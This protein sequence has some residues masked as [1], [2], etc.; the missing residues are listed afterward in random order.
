[1][2]PACLLTLPLLVAIWLVPALAFAQDAREGFV[3]VARV[4]FVFAGGGEAEAECDGDCG[5]FA[6]GDNDYDDESGP[7]IGMDF[8]G[9]VSPKLRLGG[10]LMYFPT[11]ELDFDDGGDFEV[12]SDLLT[13]FIVEGV[14][15]VSPTVALA[16]R[17]QVGAMF[18]FPDDDLEESIDDTEAACDALPGDC[19]VDD[20]PYVG[21]TF[22]LGGGAIFDVGAVALRADL[23]FQWYTINVG[24]TDYNGPVTDAE[25]Y[26]NVSGSRLILAGG[27][28]F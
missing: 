28:E 15:D 5:A 19:D 2:R 17:G 9:H 23:I 20:G 14:F 6:S 11:S 16:V 8:M 26:S 4:G 3:G 13:Q 7:M 25:L 18:L 12:G 10:G 22:G 27:I 1:L 24:K 21:F